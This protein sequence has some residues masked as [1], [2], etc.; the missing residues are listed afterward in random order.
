MWLE[1][2][3]LKVSKVQWSPLKNK[4]LLQLTHAIKKV[5]DRSYHKKIFKFHWRSF[6]SVD[7]K[8]DWF[9]IFLFQ[10]K[11]LKLYIMTLKLSHPYKDH[12]E[13]WKWPQER[14]DEIE[15]LYQWYVKNQTVINA[16]LNFPV[17]L[18]MIKQPRF[19]KMTKNHVHQFYHA[20]IYDKEDTKKAF[21]RYVE[22]RS[23]AASPEIKCL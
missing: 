22:V 15:E 12:T 18:R 14:A 9:R 16:S 1:S 23:F 3:W 19:P 7:I 17:F 21:S 13:P 11:A 5:E 4:Q 20:C 10:T 6:T 8:I 2:H